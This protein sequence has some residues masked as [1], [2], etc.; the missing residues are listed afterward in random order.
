MFNQKRFEQLENIWY[1]YKSFT[2][3]EETDEYIKLELEKKE[4]LNNA[5]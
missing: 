2:C 1:R 3:K 4:F 5:V